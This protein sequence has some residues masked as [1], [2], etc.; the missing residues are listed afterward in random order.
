MLLP[1]DILRL[2]YDDSLTRGGIEYARKSL[3]YTYNRMGLGAGARLRKIVAGVAVE[4]AFRRWLEANE[5][6]YDLLGATAFTEKDKYDLRL[7]GRRCDLK[8]FL[9]TRRDDIRELRR[10]PSWLLDAAALVPEDQFDKGSLDEHGLYLFS[11]IAGL[12]ARQM[13]DVEKALQAGQPVEL[14]HALDDEEWL[15]RKRW[16]SLG[17]LELKCDLAQALEVEVGGQSA[18]RQA[19]S[20]RIVLEPRVRAIT[21]KEFYSLLYLRAARLPEGAVGVQS[22]QLRPNKPHLIAPADW[23]NIWIYGVEIFIAGW[24]TRPE[25]RAQSRKL[26]AGSRV[27]QYRSTQTANRM[28]RVQELRPVMELAERVKAFARK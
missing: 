15:G 21:Q 25:F 28:V 6:P 20:E 7:G 23:H 12:E 11:Y 19:I 2:P 17:P 18:D 1:A 5:V 27:K 24:L 8:S 10:N 16:R 4:L 26:P 9:I 22:P 3:H 13:E 14:V